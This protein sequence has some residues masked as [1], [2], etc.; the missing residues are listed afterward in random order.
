MIEFERALIG[1]RYVDPLQLLPVVDVERHAMAQRRADLAPGL[2]RRIEHD[3]RRLEAGRQRLLELARARHLAGHALRAEQTQDAFEAAGL[4]GESVHEM[5]G[6]GRLQLAHDAADRFHVDEAGKQDLA[7]DETLRDG[8]LGYAR[9][10]DRNRIVHAAPPPASPR[11]S[12]TASIRRRSKCYLRGPQTLCEPLS[13]LVGCRRQEKRFAREAR[14]VIRSARSLAEPVEP[15]ACA[16][17]QCRDHRRH[18]S[19]SARAGC[20]PPTSR[21]WRT[22]SAR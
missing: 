21:P 2:G 1:Q 16:A 15:P 9:L 6:E 18:G 3:A 17:W 14:D 12:A 22:R 4:G 5:I 20:S 7:A 11:H 19:R 10:E 13:R 8:R